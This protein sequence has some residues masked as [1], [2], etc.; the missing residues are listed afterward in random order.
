MHDAQPPFIRRHLEAPILTALQD[1]PAV[2]VNGPRQCGKTTLVRTLAQQKGMDYLS[3][4]DPNLLQT[5]KADPVGFTQR[6]DRAVI[7]EVQRA[8]DLLLAL[9]ASIDNDRRPGRFL[10]TGSAN[11]MALPHIADS[12]AGRIEVLNL[13]PLSQ[14]ELAGRPADFLQRAIA[15]DWPLGRGGQGTATRPSPSPPPDTNGGALIH[16][17]LSGGYPEMRQRATLARKTAWA[18]S[19]VTTLIERDI[20]DVARIDDAARLPQLLALAAALSAQTPN[21]HQIGGQLSLSGKTVERY[22]GILEKIFL[23]RRLP[24]WSRHELN[25]LVKAPKLHFLD[26]GLQATLTRLTPALANTQRTRWG[27]T[28]ETWVYTEL[29]KILTVTPE[30]WFT[31]YYRD[32]DQVEVDFVLESPLREIIAI[33]VKASAS[34]NAYDFKGIKRLRDQCGPGFLT[35]IVLYDGDSALPFGSGLWA[36]PL[37]WL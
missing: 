33:E 18:Q 26:A 10:L 22:L 25:R 15:Q 1:T 12:L 32:K 29:L 7:D 8:P 14:A 20:Q 24:A 2:L 21:L 36:V 9:K 13:L 37:Q 4:D 31:S 11:L 6:I 3:L 27:A 35:G 17:V 30:Q 5:V 16:H 23:L 19:Y 34:V 28:L